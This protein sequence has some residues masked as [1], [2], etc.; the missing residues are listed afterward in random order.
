MGEAGASEELGFFFRRL[1]ELCFSP[2]AAQAYPGPAAALAVAPRAGAAFFGD[3]QGEPAG[4]TLGECLHSGGCYHTMRWA[5][6]GGRRAAR[7][8]SRCPLHLA[9]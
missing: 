9:P 5:S 3:A 1:G 4:Q 6:S 8:P 2:A 7:P